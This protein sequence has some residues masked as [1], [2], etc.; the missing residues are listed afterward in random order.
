MIV[1]RIMASCYASFDHDLAHLAV[2]PVHWFPETINWIFDEVNGIFNYVTII[3]NVGRYLL[4]Y[5]SYF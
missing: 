1:N 3:K 5:S 2:T 4:P